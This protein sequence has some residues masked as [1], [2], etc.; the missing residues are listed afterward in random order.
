MK[1]LKAELQSRLAGRAALVGV[2]NTMKG[3]D[4][5]G[6]RLVQ[7]LKGAVHAVLF[8]AGT[9][10]ENQLGP[11][12]RAAP[13]TVLIIDA[14]HFGGLPGSIRIFNPKDL[15]SVAFTTH[16]M[17]LEF[18]VRYLKKHGIADVVFLGIQPAAVNFSETV[19]LPVQK[20]LD[21]LERI[22]RSLDL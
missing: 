14:L 2:G 6:P 3:D 22:L 11:I 17:N 10:P 16:S 19:S 20:A 5:A 7:R 12:V 15:G 9:T 4:G 18:F 8:D 21:D 13:R 1:S